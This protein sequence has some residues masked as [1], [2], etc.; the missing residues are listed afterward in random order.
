MLF[1]KD[2]STK[3]MLSFYYFFHTCIPTSLALSKAHMN[4]YDTTFCING[5]HIVKTFHNY[6]CKVELD[7]CKLF[8]IFQLRILL[9]YGHMDSILTFMDLEDKIHISHR[10]IFFH[11]YA[12]HNLIKLRIY[13]NTLFFYFHKMQHFFLFYKN[14]QM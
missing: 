14:I 12:F 13:F 10:D 7:L 1:P 5:F 2:N 11:M 8:F 4:Q 6:L 9:F 3:N